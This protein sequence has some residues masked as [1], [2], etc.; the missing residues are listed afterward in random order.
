MRSFPLHAHVEIRTRVYSKS[1]NGIGGASNDGNL[2]L[3]QDQ[4]GWPLIPGAVH[5]IGSH[6]R[7]IIRSPTCTLF[8]IMAQITDSRLLSTG[9][10]HTRATS[11]DQVVSWLASQKSLRYRIRNLNDV[12]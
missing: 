10:R 1:C 11:E 4:R 5:T 6:Q 8:L 7:R 9:K 2:I 3:E 12:A